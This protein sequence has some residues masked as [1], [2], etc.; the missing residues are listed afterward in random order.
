MDIPISGFHPDVDLIW[1][2]DFIL[3]TQ[4]P[5]CHLDMDFRP[6]RV[7]L[8]SFIKS[9][10][11]MQRQKASHSLMKLWLAMPPGWVS[12]SGCPAVAFSNLIRSSLQMYDNCQDASGVPRGRE[13][14]L[15]SA[16]RQRDGTCKSLHDDSGCLIVDVH[17][18]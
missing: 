1:L 15:W 5:V 16:A 14:R 13:E 12:R 9:L 11:S 4:T 8:G 18:P 7:W 10:E 6:Q 17:V 2:G 3:I